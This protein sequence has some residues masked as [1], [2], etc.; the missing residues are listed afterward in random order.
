MFKIDELA[1][2]LVKQGR[3]KDALPVIGEELRRAIAHQVITN[4]EYFG[5]NGIMVR[6][7]NILL[8]P[9]DAEAVEKLGNDLIYIAIRIPDYVK[10]VDQR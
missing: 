4:M 6:L 7:G 3:F 2:S 10:K 8:N 5:P 9:A 1:G